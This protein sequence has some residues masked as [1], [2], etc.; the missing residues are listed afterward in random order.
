MILAETWAC[1]SVGRAHGLQPW[2]REF[3][4]PQVHQALQQLSGCGILVPPRLVTILVHVS[5]KD[6]RF[7]A[8]SS[9]GRGT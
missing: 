3:E 9:I 1:S 7:L 8:G 5:P 6:G 2:G 4:P